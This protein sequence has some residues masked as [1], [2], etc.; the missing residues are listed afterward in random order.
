MINNLRKKAGSVRSGVPEAARAS[1]RSANDRPT[2]ALVTR[3]IS[4][5]AAQGS[6][7]NWIKPQAGL[8]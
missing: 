7:P 8:I 4:L 3:R 6:F 1:D 5:D 2:E